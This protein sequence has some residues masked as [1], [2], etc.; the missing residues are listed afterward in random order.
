MD[1]DN[2]AHSNLIKARK[3]IPI[4]LK[5]LLES[6]TDVVKLCKI[7]DLTDFEAAKQIME[8]AVRLKSTI[9]VWLAYI[10]ICKKH[11]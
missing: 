2:I 4:N 11:N 1:S 10:N 7:A 3:G 5:E 9:E 8:K 6:G